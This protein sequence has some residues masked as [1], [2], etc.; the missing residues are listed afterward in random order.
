MDKLSIELLDIIDLIRKNTYSSY[1]IHI[2]NYELSIQ[3]LF[4]SDNSSQFIKNSHT[5]IVNITEDHKD[6][7]PYLNIFNNEFNKELESFNILNFNNII[8]TGPYIR[9]FLIKN[10][11]YPIRKEIYLYNCTDNKWSDILDI[12]K[13]SETKIEYI[14]ENNGFKISLIKKKYISP[15]HVILQHNFIKRVGIINNNIY[16][17]NMFLIEYLN[18]IKYL[19]NDFHDPFLN[20]PYDPLDIYQHIDNS[21]IHP[22]KA[23]ETIDIE[24]IKEIKQNQYNKLYGIKKYYNNDIIIQKLTPIEFCIEKYTK[25]KNPIILNE[26]RN[27]IIFLNNE[28]YKRPPFIYAKYINLH[29][30]D[31]KIYNILLLTKNKYNID[32]QYINKIFN[33]NCCNID[34][35]VLE[36]LIENKMN[37]EFIKYLDYIEFNIVDHTVNNTNIIID[38]IIKHHKRDNLEIV[39]LLLSTNKI[40]NNLCYYI[41]LFSENFKI[42]NLFD[43]DYE[44]AFNY[45]NDIVEKCLYKSIYFL[46]E[47]DD[48]LINTLDSNGN[49][50]FHKIKPISD[51]DSLKDTIDLLL[52]FS[53]TLINKKN[54]D[55]I[56]PIMYYAKEYPELLLYF[57]DYDIDVFKVDNE[58]NTFLHYLCAN[59]NINNLKILKIYIK[60]YQNII[61]MSNKNLETPAIIACINKNEDIFYILKSL[62]GDLSSADRYGNT[63]YHYICRN[64]ICIGHIIENTKNKFGLSPEDYCS[65]SKKFYNFIDN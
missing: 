34:L 48:T 29:T 46:L 39:N 56:T 60:K 63:V 65:I 41:C 59:R 20:V 8:I 21:I 25:E 16:V 28:N 61:N 51:K 52:V 14:S 38:M 62:G 4:S 44:I 32:E 6:L 36:Y 40:D 54:N 13:F 3:K 1:A 18:H 57:I 37:T 30:I 50:I 64:A 45:F 12:S 27:I 35:Y 19:E 55:G 5:Y 58:E 47:K 49:N 42:S 22:I 31:D 7:F 43:F 15:S 24:S 53:P 23:I 17:S 26:L 33:V 2:K 11:N 10:L 9:S